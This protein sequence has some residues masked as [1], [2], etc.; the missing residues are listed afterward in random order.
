M[1]IILECAALLNRV[2]LDG[3]KEWQDGNEKVC[4]IYLKWYESRGM[5][6]TFAKMAWLRCYDSGADY[7]ELPLLGEQDELLNL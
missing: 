7:Y 3:T 1:L 5:T 6:M 2:R 4:Q